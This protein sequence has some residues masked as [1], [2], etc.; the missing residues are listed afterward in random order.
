MF[1]NCNGTMYEQK[2]DW[3]SMRGEVWENVEP[4]F[5]AYRAIVDLH[6]RFTIRVIRFI[7][8]ANGK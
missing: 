4:C 6:E 3:S 7:L 1:S 2:E 8:A 5:D